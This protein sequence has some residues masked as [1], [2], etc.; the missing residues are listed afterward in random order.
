MFTLFRNWH[1]MNKSFPRRCP[2]CGKINVYVTIIR[3]RTARKVDG[4]LYEFE[5][6]DVTVNQCK[7][8]KE[9]SIPQK[10]LDQVE[11]YFIKTFLS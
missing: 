9:Y 2:T 3:Y 1:L 8:C 11:E 10:T 7:T 6:P 4:V 5:T